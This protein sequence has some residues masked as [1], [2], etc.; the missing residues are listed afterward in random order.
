MHQD[1]E[2]DISVPLF[3][4]HA[5]GICKELFGRPFF[6]VSKGGLVARPIVD[7]WK[8]DWIW[9][10]VAEP[11]RS[12]L[13]IAKGCNDPTAWNRHVILHGY[14]LDYGTE[15]N[16]LKAIS[17]LSFLCGLDNYA[18]EKETELNPERDG[19]L[20][21]R[22]FLSSFTDRKC[23]HLKTL[24]EHAE[25]AATRCTENSLQL[26]PADAVFV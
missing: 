8:I 10:A 16:S 13:S 12:Q 6:K 2:Y 15:I 3:L 22:T 18:C 17:L 9:T 4:I 23:K 1:R 26:L 21:E 24:P 7:K 11:F 14:N 25:Q 20:V 19:D 5:D